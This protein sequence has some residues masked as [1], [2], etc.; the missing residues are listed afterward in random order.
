MIKSSNLG[1]GTK[2]KWSGT[3]DFITYLDLYLF[4]MFYLLVII[5]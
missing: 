5:D 4:Q 3:I 2:N 1:N